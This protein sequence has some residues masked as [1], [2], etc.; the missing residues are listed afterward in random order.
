MILSLPPSPLV[1]LP[2]EILTMPPLPPVAAPEPTKMLPEFPLPAVPE[3][4]T[5]AP[6][7]PLFP[8]FVD[9]IVTV[10][11]V[12]VEPIP[13]EISTSPPVRDS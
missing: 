6:E 4:N 5:N 3:L 1:P 8:A 2:T 9:R 13:A 10:P 11:D 12:V 7:A